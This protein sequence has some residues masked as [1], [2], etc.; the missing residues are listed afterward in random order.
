MNTLDVEFHGLTDSVAL[1][2]G[3]LTWHDQRSWFQF[4]RDFL[5]HGVNP[6]PFGLKFT[7]ELQETKSPSYNGMHGLFNESL[8]DGWG[9]FLMNRTFEQNGI[10]FETASPV[11]RLSY[12]GGNGMGALSYSPNHRLVSSPS[13]AHSLN[14][15]DLQDDILN[16]L[17]G[18]AFSVEDCHAVN[19]IPPAGARPK[20]LVGFDGHTAVEGAGELPE[21]YAPWIVKFSMLPTS[22]ENT[23]GTIEYLYAK[24]AM[25]AG[26]HMSPVRLV[27]GSK[28]STYFMTRRFDRKTNC[29]RVHVQSVASLLGLDC[30]TTRLDYND[31]FKLCDALTRNYTYKLYLFKQMVFN[32]MAGNRGDHARN[33]AFMLT[34]NNEWSCTPAYDVGWNVG[35]STGH[36]TSINGSTNSIAERDIWDASKRASIPK[37]D[38]RHVLERV[39]N[40]LTNWEQLARECDLPTH[41]RQEI[42][43][44][45]QRQQR[46][47]LPASRPVTTSS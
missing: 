20:L 35:T 11:E 33:F 15:D 2:M 7:S 30:R 4:S 1:P 37:R 13:I 28:G 17:E 25:D 34:D 5:E 40:A 9:L 22:G 44:Y 43:N 29:R 6:S 47:M 21:G 14:L 38:V 24:M 31:L 32:A 39:A 23:E 3:R 12:I 41:K 18:S 8:P 16:L 42:S 10:S 26:V 19:G 27:H 46:T 45:I 36:A